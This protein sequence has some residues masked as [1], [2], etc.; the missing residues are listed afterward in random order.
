[1]ED[2]P[3]LIASPRLRLVVATMRIS[4]ATGC[5]PPTRSASRPAAHAGAWPG[6]EG[7]FG[8]LVEGAG[9]PLLGLP[10]LDSAWSLLGAGESSPFS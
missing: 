10:E 8:R 1:M 7:H 4:R 9:V 6:A 3:S 5:L 2:A